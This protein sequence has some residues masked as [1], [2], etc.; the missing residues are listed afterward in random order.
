MSATI[1]DVARLAGVSVATVSRALTGSGP[2]SGDT[3]ARIVAAAEELR[4]T[5]NASARS[6]VS[7]RTST[8]GFLLPDLYGEFFSEVIRGA[9]LAARAHGYHLLV[10]ST[11]G[12][13][14][15]AEAALHAMRG[16]VDGLLVMAPDPGA[17]ALAADLPR[18][19]PVVLLN[20]PA[21]LTGADAVA[22][23]SYGGARAMVRHLLAI[24]HR[25][26]AYVAGPESNHDAAERRRGWRTALRAGG[27]VPARDWEL[28]GD[29]T[30]D[31]GYAAARRLLAASGAG[32]A[33]PT[34]IFAAN[35]VMAIGAI[36]A[37]GEAGLRVPEDVA[38]VGFDDI[39]MA[40]YVNPPL[41]SVHVAIHEL[42]AR[43]VARLIL[44]MSGGATHRPYRELIAA[45]LVVRASCGGRAPPAAD[46]PARARASPRR[47]A[48]AAPR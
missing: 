39:P 30:E 4:Y 47:S 16:R 20:G 17:A 11:H 13:R 25:R 22:V 41:T 42:G 31:G 37:V 1:R 38:V 34:A 14:D 3:R 7:S 10:S 40:R 15:E 46:M 29:F 36:S 5:P 21:R 26:I 33:R 24:G 27:I 8:V 6:L 32:T 2:V 43:A 35:D 18:S 9:D 19:V 48:T 44:A 23:D 12:G 28:P 45:T